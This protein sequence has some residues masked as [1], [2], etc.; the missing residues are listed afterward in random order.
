MAALKGFE[1][2]LEIDPSCFVSKY[3]V[4]CTKLL[5][6]LT[7]EATQQFS[8]ILEVRPSYLPALKGSGSDSFVYGLSFESNSRYDIQDWAKH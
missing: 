8:A 7:E 4:A 6:G 5:L 1:K 3:Q 2:A